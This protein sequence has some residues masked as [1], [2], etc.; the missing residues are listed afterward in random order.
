M[1]DETSKKEDSKKNDSKKNDSKNNDS[2]NND[3]KSTMSEEMTE[4]MDTSDSENDTSNSENE[5]MLEE[6]SVGGKK[7]K[8]FFKRGDMS[9]VEKMAKN[10]GLS[11]GTL[12][13]CEGERVKFNTY[14]K[15]FDVGKKSLEE[16][17]KAPKEMVEKA[18]C[19]YFEAYTVGE[20]NELPSR[21]YADT[22]RSHLRMLIKEKTNGQIDLTDEFQMPKFD[23]SCTII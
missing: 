13:K 2:K 23:V 1:S 21:N 18:V 5:T 12:K 8:S 11:A 10:K 19:E 16:F 14:C 6:K 20:N 15:T 7:R 4:A 3:S 9:N 22:I 17:C